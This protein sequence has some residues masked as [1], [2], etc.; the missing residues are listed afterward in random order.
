MCLIPLGFFFSGSDDCSPGSRYQL[1][2]LEWPFCLAIGCVC[3]RLPWRSR[4]GRCS[5]FRRDSRPTICHYAR[6]LIQ[7]IDIAQTIEYKTIQWLNRNLP[8]QR[9]LV[10]GDTEWLYNDFLRQSAAERRP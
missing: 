10:S 2:L 1:E 9:A 3:A 6:G 4:S 7:P 5:P 8:G